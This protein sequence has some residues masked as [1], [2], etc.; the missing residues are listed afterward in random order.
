MQSLYAQYYRIVWYMY[1]KVALFNIYVQEVKKYLWGVIFSKSKLFEGV[2]YY[3]TYVLV[4]S[5]VPC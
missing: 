3:N 5:P 2:G 4:V 1:I